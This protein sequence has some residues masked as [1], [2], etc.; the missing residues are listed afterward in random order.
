M[1]FSFFWCQPLQLDTNPQS[2]NGESSDLP[3]A[4][5]RSAISIF[6]FFKLKNKTLFD[7]F[8]LAVPA[9]LAALKPASME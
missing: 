3:L 1:L 9:A 6:T 2:C 8:L 5:D 7:I 4:Q